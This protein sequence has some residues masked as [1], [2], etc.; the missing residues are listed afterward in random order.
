VSGTRRSGICIWLHFSVTI[1]QYRLTNGS[2]LD[3][4]PLV[5]VYLVGGGLLLPKRMLVSKSAPS[6]RWSPGMVMGCPN[7][8][9]YAA[10]MALIKRG[11]ANMMSMGWE[12]RWCVAGRGWFGCWASWRLTRSVSAR[13]GPNSWSGWR[14]STS[15]LASMQNR[16]SYCCARH[17]LTCCIRSST[18]CWRG[19]GWVF[20]FAR[21]SRYCWSYAVL[22]P[23]VGG[24]GPTR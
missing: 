3:C 14:F 18:N 12:P 24:L 5:C 8:S 13:M 19:L 4:T 10:V 21:R 1:S 15:S 17:C 16:T 9:I 7:G 6:V 11:E 20:P 22:A 2:A 23:S